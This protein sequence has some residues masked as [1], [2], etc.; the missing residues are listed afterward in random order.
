MVLY[1]VHYYVLPYY[2][3][4]IL[5]YYAASSADQHP[6]VLHGRAIAAFDGQRYGREYMSLQ[7]GQEVTM[8][9]CCPDGWAYGTIPNTNAKGWFPKSHWEEDL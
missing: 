5:L 1:N 2:Y 4:I 8:E 3:I 9:N 6:A 7:Q